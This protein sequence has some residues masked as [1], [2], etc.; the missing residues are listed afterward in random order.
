MC[1]FLENKGF[2]YITT[3]QWSKWGNSQLAEYL[4]YTLYAVFTRSPILCF[5]EK[6]NPRSCIA[7]MYHVYSLLSSGRVFGFSFIFSYTDIFD[8][9]RPVILYNVLL[10]G[11]ACCFLMIRSRSFTFGNNIT[12]VMLDSSRCIMSIGTC[13][14]IIP[15]FEI[16]TLITQLRW[17]ARLDHCKLLL[18]TL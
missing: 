11:F 3:L 17:P 10:S 7:C 9:H 6:E 5:I 1:T 8:K 15:I 14:Q 12:G 16:L 18:Y 4:I 13:W 2:F